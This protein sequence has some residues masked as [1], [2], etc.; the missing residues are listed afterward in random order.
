MI[1]TQALKGIPNP[2]LSLFRP[3][4]FL[5]IGIHALLL[6][7]PIPS[8][9]KP[10]E[11]SDKKDPIKI[12][13]IPTAKPA[14]PKAVPVVKVAKN[15]TTATALVKSTPTT[16]SP[17]RLSPLTSPFTTPTSTNFSSSDSLASS[18]SSTANSTSPSKPLPPDATGVGAPGT[19]AKKLKP[20]ITNPIET[21]YGI[22]TSL[23]NAETNKT[24]SDNLPNQ[25][26]PL[27]EINQPELLFKPTGNSSSKPEKVLPEGLPGLERSPLLVTFPV[28]DNLNLTSFYQKYLEAKIKDLFD[29][30]EVSDYGDGPLYKLTNADS[31]LFLSLMPPKKAVGTVLSVWSK[32]PREN[33]KT[34]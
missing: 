13:Q 20:A 22:L 4:L 21:L 25:A 7:T 1:K 14:V 8:E 16:T 2:L 18:S 15:K 27:D 10:K 34:R 28:E 23:P 19:I 11:P 12:T 9:T 33:L 24:A 5:A 17:I 6:F 32:D 29:V 3:I 31:T 30:E 26:V